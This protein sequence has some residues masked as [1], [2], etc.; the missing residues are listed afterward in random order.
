[1]Q[2]NIG[3]RSDAVGRYLEGEEMFLANYGDGL[4]DAPLDEMIDAFR[5][6]AARSAL[7]SFGPQFND[8]IVDRDERA[9]VTSIERMSDSDVWINGGFFIFRR[10][11]ST[12]SSRARS[13]SRRPFAR[14]I[15][16]R[17]AARLPVRGFFGPMDTIK[18]QQPL[19][20][21]ARA[22]PCALAQG[23]VARGT[24]AEAGLMLALSFLRP[25]DA[26]APP[27]RARR[28]ADD[29]EIG[30]GGRSS[31]CRRARPTSRSRGSCFGAHGDREARGAGERRGLPR[32]RAA[33]AEVV[34]HG[35]RDG[36]SLHGAAV[37][38]SSRS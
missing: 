12:T 35:F 2:S 25:R 4:T 29:I 9:V 3:E 5:G 10:E 11:S 18:D 21:L 31:R 33:G 26:A 20:A 22:R 24:R 37:K 14:L 8:H 1:M 36:F 16:T 32:R 17:R 23:R 27:A 19:E 38:D 30:C 15:P 7:L 28:H 6:A 34:V 13:W